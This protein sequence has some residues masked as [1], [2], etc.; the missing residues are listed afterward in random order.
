MALLPNIGRNYFGKFVK[1]SK[2]FKN[3]GILLDGKKGNIEIFFESCRFVHILYRFQ[4]Q[5]PDE[6]LLKLNGNAIPSQMRFPII[7]TVT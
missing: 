5:F 2:F 7:A 4:S 1:S 3:Q 6:H